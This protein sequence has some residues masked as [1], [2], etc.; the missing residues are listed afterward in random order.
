MRYFRYVFVFLLI[1]FAFFLIYSRFQ[2]SY[3]DIPSLFKEAHKKPLWFLIVLELGYLLTLG[4]LSKTLLG[5]AGAKVSWKETVQ[6]GTLTTLGFQVAPFVGGAALAYL[7]YKRLKVPSSAVFFSVATIF[8]FNLLNYFV[9]TSLSLVFVRQSFLSLLPG[10]EVLVALIVLLLILSFIYFLFRNRGKGLISLLCFGAGLVDKLGRRLFK[11]QIITETR[12][13]R[14][15]HEFLQDFDLLSANPKKAAFALSLSLLSYLISLSILYLCFFSFGYKASLPLLVIGLT[16]S[17]LFS[18]LSLFP[19]A[20]GVIE[21]SL[22]TV[23]VTLGFPAHVALFTSLL[24]RIISYWFLMPFGILVY[25]R[26]NGRVS[27][28]SFDKRN[29]E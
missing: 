13:Q 19:E 2:A 8:S 26:L 27:K 23:F 22:V 3:H 7:F 17:L 1:G 18:V 28:E 10:K 12:V 15:I 25:L 4:I 21:A 24:Y 11:K 14:V 5:I 9:I 16:G 29:S 6:A 20:P